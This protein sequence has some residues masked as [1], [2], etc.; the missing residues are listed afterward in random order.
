MLPR[1]LSRPKNLLF[2]EV[3]RGVSRRNSQSGTAAAVAPPRLFKTRCV[4]QQ[5]LDD[6]RGVADVPLDAATGLERLMNR[7]NATELQESLEQVDKTNTAV[8]G[9]R[10]STV[11]N[12]RTRR[13]KAGA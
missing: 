3:P 1:S 13:R 5:D 4:T 7:T 12:A 9:L 10:S 11:R 2:C 6:L 8:D